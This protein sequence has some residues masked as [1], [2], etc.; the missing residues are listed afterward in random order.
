MQFLAEVADQVPDRASRARDMLENITYIGE[1]ERTEAMAGI[2]EYWKSWLAEN[3]DRQICALASIS[4]NS[5]TNK[6]DRYLLDGILSNFSDEELAQIGDRL[7]T[8]L[9]D[10]TGA[11]EDVKV[12]LLDDWTISGSQMETA[13]GTVAHE[14]GQYVDSIELQLVTSTEE[15]IRSGKTVSRQGRQ[16]V[17]PIRS[18]FLSHRAAV[19]TDYGYKGHTAYETGSHSSVDF[20]FQDMISAMKYGLDQKTGAVTIMPPTTNIRR[21]YKKA[22]LGNISRLQGRQR[23]TELAGVGV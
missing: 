22:K 4:R 19:E 5:G 17:I 3:P 12:V 14:A 1:K 9:S 20:D 2:A 23:T 6:S 21:I 13:L 18:Y 11:P 7:V 10:L 16:H 8:G 15:R